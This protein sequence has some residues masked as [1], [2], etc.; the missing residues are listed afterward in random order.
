M[1]WDWNYAPAEIVYLWIPERKWNDASLTLISQADLF[2]LVWSRFAA[3]S[4]FVDKEWRHAYSL[5]RDAA[6]IIRPVFWTQPMPAPPRELADRAFCLCARTPGVRAGL[7]TRGRASPAQQFTMTCEYQRFSRNPPPTWAVVGELAH[8]RRY[9]YGV[10]RQ[11]RRTQANRC[12]P[13]DLRN[14]GRN[15]GTRPAL[16]AAS[17][18]V[19]SLAFLLWVSLS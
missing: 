6:R 15:Q 9:Q 12:H 11:R 3:A 1:R 19:L 16:R 2:Q 17:V 13:A 10:C 7:L 18:S 8:Q 4:H 5:R 14:G